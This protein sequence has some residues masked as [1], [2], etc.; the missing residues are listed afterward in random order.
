M[1]RR[2]RPQGYLKMALGSSRFY[3]ATNEFWVGTLC[4]DT[5]GFDIELP[6]YSPQEPQ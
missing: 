2:G 1:E 6:L 4:Q 3:F 5:E